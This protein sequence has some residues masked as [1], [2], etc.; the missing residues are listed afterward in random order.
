MSYTNPKSTLNLAILHHIMQ[1]AATRSVDAIAAMNISADELRDLTEMTGE[2]LVRFAMI[3]DSLFEIEFISEVWQK[4]KPGMQAHAANRKLR[5]DLI[6][7]GAPRAMIERWWPM[8]HADF[9]L[10]RRMFGV[11]ALGRARA[12]TAEEEHRLWDAWKTIVADRTVDVLEA[13]DY[14]NLFNRTKINLHVSWSLTNRWAAEGHIDTES[15][16]VGT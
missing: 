16:R 2:D 8:R 10:L 11:K 13:R 1:C 4:C 3:S 12:P 15:R 5:N 6:V 9:A 14:L 7:A